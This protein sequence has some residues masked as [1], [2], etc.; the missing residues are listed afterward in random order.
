MLCL[1]IV[2]ML[3][4]AAAAS[5]AIGASGPVRSAASG[6]AA[7]LMLY[8]ARDGNDAWG[9]RLATPNGAA[10]GPLATLTAARDR[11]RDLKG[12]GMLPAGATVRIR[13]GTYVLDQPLAF[14]SRDSGAPGAPI[15]Y[16]A[17]PGEKVIITGGRRITGWKPASNGLWVA[18]LPDLD[19]KPWKFSQLF[20]NGQA[21]PRSRQPNT[22]NWREWPLTTDGF[23]HDDRHVREKSILVHYPESVN[24]R[25]WPNLGDVEINILASWRWVNK[26][27]PLQAVDEKNR[28]ATLAAPAAYHI[29]KNDPFRV[30]NVI[31]AID[32]PGEWCT[33]T[34]EKTIHVLPPAGVDM[35]K[36]E[37]MAPA[38]KTLV[39]I[40]GQDEGDRLA[41][42]I[43]FRGF[44]FS[45]AG[46]G[47][48]LTNAEGCV[49][50][51]CRF[52]NLEGQAISLSQYAQHNR[53]AGNEI[54]YC[55]AGGVSVTGYPAGTKDV[56]HH[57]V[58]THNHIHHC[59]RTAWNAAGIGLPQSGRNIVA[60]NYIH[61]MPY[62]GILAGGNSIVYFNMYAAE[63]GGEFRWD[64][65][66]NDPLT[67][68]SVKKF[69]HARY[70]LIANNVITSFMQQLEDGG[71]IY[72]WCPGLGNVIRDNIVGGTPKGG[73]AVGIYM[74]DEVDGALIERNLVYD[75]QR[76]TINKG[77]NVWRDNEMLDRV[78]ESSLPA[79]VA[80]TGRAVARCLARPTAD[81]EFFDARTGLPVGVTA[82]IPK[83]PSPAYDERIKPGKGGAYLSDLREAS[84]YA[85]GGLGKNRGYGAEQILTLAGR[86][87]RKGLVM[88]PLGALDSQPNNHDSEAVYDLAG[89]GWKRFRAR[90]GIE[91]PAGDNPQGSAT[92][93]VYTRKAADAPWI[94]IYDSGV[95]TWASTP[96]VADLDIT[97]A[98]QLRLRC[99][100]AGDDHFG[101]VAVWASACVE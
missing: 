25:D 64:E 62:I 60:F 39:R 101:D 37:V 77:D 92:F 84:A 38:V 69:L 40:E 65:I 89:R 14:D 23:A 29:N 90:I 15:I 46:D 1:A 9:G 48:G 83:S 97:G 99:T 22:D 82:E 87:Y 76:L 44:T 57:N 75:V 50:E 21:Q 24:I 30:E 95:M 20:V 45:Q 71:G 66:G 35:A 79:I 12:K 8:V 53:I 51:N 98:A 43:T 36:A 42:D 58:I 2:P 5:T 17:Y 100:D 80:R 3:A 96:A 55:G 27:I 81:E 73:L 61:D 54:A 31:D 70:N 41:R 74:D 16:S 91:V 6:H 85:H 10:D 26:V 67:R 18:P 4:G 63:K 28:V 13:G 52:L 68:E 32:E 88:H 59:G 78:P 49:V 33:N 11:V 19:G 7:A 72:M 34:L 94:R 93:E 86:A 56:S 47:I